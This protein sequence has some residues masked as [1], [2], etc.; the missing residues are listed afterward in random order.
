MTT[1][2]QPPAGE[3]PAPTTPATPTPETPAG[4]LLQEG[5]ANAGDPAATPAPTDENAWL[6]EKFQVKDAEGK[7]DEAASARKLA[8]S[9]K[10]LEAHKGPI[11]Q[12]PATPDGYV[13][14]APKGEDGQP[15]P[16]VDMEQF[17]ADPMFKEIAADAHAEGISNKTMQFFMDKYFAIAP[18]LIQAD[19][20]LTVEEAS[21]ELSDFWKTEQA[22]KAN[23]AQAFRAVT[24][25]GAPASDVPGSVD[26]LNAKFGND[27]DFI[28]LMATIGA[29]M[30]EDRLPNETSVTS[31]IDIE[32]M[33]KSKAY[34]DKNDP[35]H[36]RVKNAVQQHFARIHGNKPH[37]RAA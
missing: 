16:G 10:A 18:Q 17:M 37:G 12:A 35:D 11:Q 25:F 14:E 5:A 3:N 20:Q 27:P 15:L 22:F 31:S 32:A 23:T 13:I 6:P 4:T 34:F 19:Q 9:Y 26:R 36:T 29:E 2:T 21:R 28:A 24:A 1:E 30:K 8:E 7:L 33:M